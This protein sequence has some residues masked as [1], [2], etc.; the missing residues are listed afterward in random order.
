MSVQKVASLPPSLRSD[1]VLPVLLRVR[2]CSCI[3]PGSIKISGPTLINQ[4][5]EKTGEDC[6]GRDG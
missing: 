4:R 2:G 6:S 5:S 1:E 3:R